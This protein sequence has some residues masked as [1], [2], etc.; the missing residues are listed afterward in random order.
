LARCPRALLSANGL[1]DHPQ[2]AASE[3]EELAATVVV[4]YEDVARR[5]QSDSPKPAE[6]AVRHA[7]SVTGNEDV[8]FWTKAR[9]I[10]HRRSYYCWVGS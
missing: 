7:H 3:V 4:V 9:S 6:D 2:G 10:D 5:N 8:R 1:V